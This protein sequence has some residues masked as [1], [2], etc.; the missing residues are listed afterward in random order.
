ML[1]Y[2]HFNTEHMDHRT[3]HNKDKLYITEDSL[4]K[5]L[6]EIQLDRKV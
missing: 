2:G 1:K 5:A 6:F 3:L 4:L